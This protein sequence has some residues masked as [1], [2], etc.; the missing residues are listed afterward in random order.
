MTDHSIAIRQEAD[1]QP[2]ELLSAIAT[3]V[4]NPAID[5]A[6]MER[7]LAMHKEIVADQRKQAFT[8]A[9][10]QLKP[11]LPMIDKNGVIMNKDRVT[12]RAKYAKYEDIDV[13][14]KPILDEFGFAFTFDSEAKGDGK[15]YL[16]I[17]DLMHRLGHIERKTLLLPVDNSEY[18][19]AVQNVASTISFGK[20]QLVKMHLNL[21]EKG[22]EDPHG[23][24]PI[25]DGDQARDIHIMIEDAKADK[26][27]FLQ[28]MGVES[29]EA[30]PVRAVPTA[31]RFLKMKMDARAKAKK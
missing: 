31:I 12:V 27:A 6:K 4:T 19:S 17:A 9:L 7:L 10:V 11:R 1:L 25:G 14:I 23:L 20:R 24:A 30:I 22:D 21:I 29:V 15:Q 8:D 3:A 18:R 5:V 2:T 13:Q 16:I 28:L 26:V